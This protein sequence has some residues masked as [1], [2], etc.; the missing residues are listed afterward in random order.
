[1]SEYQYYEFQAIDRPLGEADREALRG[2][3]SRAQITATSF[4]NHYNYGDFKGNRRELMTRW[5]DLHLYVANWGTRQLMVRLPKRLLD[6]DRLD[7]LLMGTDLATVTEAGENLILDICDGGEDAEHVDWED[8]SGWLSALAPLR[9]DLLSGD[10]RLVYLIWLTGVE[11]GHVRD[12]ALEPLPGIAPLN[13][14]LKAFADFF[15]IDADLVQAAAEMPRGCAQNEKPSSAALRKA[16]A[17]MPGSQRTA[18][19][20]RLAEGEPHVGAELRLELRRLRS[21][22]QQA[23]ER[24]ALR[25]AAELRDRAKAVRKD[26]E[27]A[28][29]E[30]RR[31]ERQRQERLQE[32][33]RQARLAALRRQGAEAWRE[34]EAEV[35]RRN[36]SGYDRAASLIFDLRRLADEDGQ[37]T[38]FTNRLNA[39]RQRHERKQRFIERLSRL[40]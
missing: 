31:A 38:D 35:E 3:S 26:R 20:L 19:L 30:R 8:G 33:A 10:W 32:Q 37:T 22:Q 13:G 5:F 9:A 39:L 21:R 28:Q 23:L 40:P 36:A 25:S 18:L 24:P 6:R 11:Q 17:A 14:G 1:M 2:L 15:R 7:A 16:I 4:T 29:A 34:V 12:E 27:N